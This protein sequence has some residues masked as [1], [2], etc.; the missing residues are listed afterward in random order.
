MC[1]T[2][3]SHMTTFCIFDLLQWHDTHHR[4]DR[5][6]VGGENE[7]FVELISSTLSRHRFCGLNNFDSKKLISTSFRLPP[8][9]YL[10]NGVPKM[11]RDVQDNILNILNLQI[12]V[13][14]IHSGQMT[15][16]VHV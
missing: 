11:Y 2:V 13:M 10:R 1:E 5:D 8:I 3:I 4:P 9:L 6:R 15:E 7:S 16:Y 12:P 14:Y